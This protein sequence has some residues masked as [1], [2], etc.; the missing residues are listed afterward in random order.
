MA[1]EGNTARC[2]YPLWA[3]WAEAGAQAFVLVLSCQVAA[4]PGNPPAL[5]LLLSG[6]ELDGGADAQAFG[7][8]RVIL[9]Q[10]R[11]DCLFGGCF[12]SVALDFLLLLSLAWQASSPGQDGLA[13]A[14]RTP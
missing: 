5:R 6:R 9:R 1:R 14:Q 11:Q 10:V 2:V 12:F 3:L 4:S 13:A 7:Q 8:I